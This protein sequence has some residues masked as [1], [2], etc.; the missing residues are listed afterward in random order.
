MARLVDPPDGF[1]G[2]EV[3]FEDRLGL[4]GLGGRVPMSSHLMVWFGGVGLE[5][6]FLVGLVVV[7][8]RGGVLEARVSARSYDGYQRKDKHHGGRPHGGTEGQI[9]LS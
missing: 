3:D 6:D 5:G 2:D 4:R 8:V 9:G 7:E 1:L